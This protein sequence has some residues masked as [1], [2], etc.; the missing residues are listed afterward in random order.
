MAEIN[1]QSFLFTAS[2]LL[3]AANPPGMGPLGKLPSEGGIP[4]GEPA[5]K[6]KIRIQGIKV[7]KTGASGDVAVY[8]S[9]DTNPADPTT[10]V[11]GSDISDVVTNLGVNIKS[12]EVYVRV[13]G[14][15]QV[16]LYV[17]LNS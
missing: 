3:S 13:T 12:G 10:Q 14:G 5:L 4:A 2:G 7:L 16:W 9:A 8:D 6:R 11:Y 17:D 1:N 15:F